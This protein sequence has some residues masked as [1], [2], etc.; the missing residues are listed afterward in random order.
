MIVGKVYAVG[1]CEQDNRHLSSCE[2]FLPSLNQWRPLAPMRI[3]RRGL[4][5]CAL[6]PEHGPIYAVGR[7]PSNLY[8]SSENASANYPFIAGGLDDINFFN[9]VERYDLHSDSWTSVAPM[10]T[11]RGGVA[12]V[13]VQVK[14]KHFKVKRS[15]L[16]MFFLSLFSVFNR[17]HSRAQCT[18]SVETS[19][20]RHC[21][22]VRSIILIL[23][24]GRISLR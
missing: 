10:L 5:I 23:I 8:D 4:G 13:A 2:V 1:G 7:S 21:Q 3:P 19:A 14:N 9:T 22:H 17:N 6:S 24:N 11:P 12:V 16:S 20:R 15:S 18:R